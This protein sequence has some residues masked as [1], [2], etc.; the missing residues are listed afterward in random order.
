MTC[1]TPYL[2]SDLATHLKIMR[3]YHVVKRSTDYLLEHLT[4]YYLGFYLDGYK[5]YTNI[6]EVL[7]GQGRLKVVGDPNPHPF[8][9][10]I[11]DIYPDDKVFRIKASLLFK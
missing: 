1:P 11:K 5:K 9:G 10:D 4:Q 2:A 8:E 7:P 3:D 6:S